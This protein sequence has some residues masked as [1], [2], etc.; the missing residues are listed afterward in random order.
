MIAFTL[1]DVVKGFRCRHFF[2]LESDQ[3]QERFSKTVLEEI[4]KLKNNDLVL[5]ESLG[6]IFVLCKRE[7]EHGI[8]TWVGKYSVLPRA[9]ADRDGSYFGVGVW[10]LNTMLSGKETVDV[11]ESIESRLKECISSTNRYEWDLASVRG[12]YLGIDQRYTDELSRRED[13]RVAVGIVGGGEEKLGFQEVSGQD[14]AQGVE[15]ICSGL[16]GR[17][18]SRVILTSVSEAATMLRHSQYANEIRGFG[19]A[20]TTRIKQATHVNQ[21]R[22]YREGGSHGE[23]GTLTL[24]SKRFDSLEGLITQSQRT[25]QMVFLSTLVCAA[26]FA[27]ATILLVWDRVQSKPISNDA[28]ALQIGQDIGASLNRAVIYENDYN[29][30]VK[31]LVVDIDA[32]LKRNELKKDSTLRSTLQ[33]ARDEAQ[34]QL[35]SGRK[36]AE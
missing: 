17:E 22:A 20:L 33:H 28:G 35:D 13:V 21:N 27:G 18:F 31:L 14:F 16:K 1:F 8:L 19:A 12:S 4:V 10:F 3:R 29:D 32:V 26:L 7:T 36:A 2:R 30:Q 6:S 34:K 24:F 25:W 11:L 5:T 23:S 15:D 9:Y